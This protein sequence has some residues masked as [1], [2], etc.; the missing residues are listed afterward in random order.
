MDV[1]VANSIERS[2]KIGV[3]SGNQTLL[4]FL[5]YIEYILLR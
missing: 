3:P 2:P 1:F 4:I 5:T